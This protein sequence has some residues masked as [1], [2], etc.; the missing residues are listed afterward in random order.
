MPILDSSV[1]DSKSSCCHSAVVTV[2]G[3][4]G[5]NHYE[6]L[7]CKKAC[8]VVQI[9]F[10]PKIDW[11][12]VAVAIGFGLFC[13]LAGAGLIAYEATKTYYPVP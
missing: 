1:L 8:D 7:S 5:T 10:E 2:Y 12:S 13:F 4:E 11:L 6:C 3:G 9:P